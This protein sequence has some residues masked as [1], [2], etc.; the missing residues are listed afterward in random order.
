MD[1]ISNVLHRQ[2]PFEEVFISLYHV[3][4]MFAC[5]DIFAKPS[6]AHP[7]KARVGMKSRDLQRKALCVHYTIY[8]ERNQDSK[9]EYCPHNF[10]VLL[11][12]YYERRRTDVELR[13]GIQKPS[14]SE[15]TI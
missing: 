7:R 2:P 15:R 14:V 4:K 1:H 12:I 9:Y 8:A 6:M 13:M 10:K 11:K 3:A 5:K